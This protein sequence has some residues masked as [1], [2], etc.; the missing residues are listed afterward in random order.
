MLDHRFSVA[1]MMDWTDRHQRYF[2]RLI[3]RR[4]VL[5][6]EMVTEA[7][8]RFGD[9]D[10]LLGFDAAEHP[11]VLQLGG[12]DPA[13]MAEAA[14]IGEGFGY[15][16]ININ[17][18]CPSDRVQSGAFGA[19]LMAR[20]WVVAEC[21]AAMTAAVGVPVTVKTRIGIDEN[22]SYEALYDFVSQVSAAGCGRFVIHA[23]KAWL[24]GLSP[25]QNREVP[26]LRYEVVHRLKGDFPGLRFV[27][28][29]GLRDPDVALREGQ[30]LD[31][32]MLGRAAYHDPYLLAQVDGRFYV[33]PH[34]IPSR[35]EVLEA[36][37][38]YL[39]ARLAE[40]IA[41]KSI[42]RHLLGLFQG[43]PGAKRWRRRLSE[44]A[45]LPGA[46]IDLL[47]QAASLVRAD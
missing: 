11:L 32:V 35:H 18:G 45:H 10:H 43:V 13:N 29:G 17:V 2:L 19:C 6:T 40:G 7:A 42:S 9:R 22:D 36:F 31:G 44:Q 12:S 21:V 1:P 23:R 14:R 4:A 8:V 38:P 5:Y 33:D 47:R 25:K 46:G 27:L 20:P 37:I 28:N 3:S 16:E 26:P 30:G 41:F 34:P 24:Q 39:D 15:D